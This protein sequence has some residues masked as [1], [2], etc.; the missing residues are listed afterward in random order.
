MG[1][2]L[3]LVDHDALFDYSRHTAIVVNEY[4]LDLQADLEQLNNLIYTTYDANVLQL[5]PQC[6]CQYLKGGQNVGLTCPKCHTQCLTVTEKPLESVLWIAAPSEVGVLI[7]PQAWIIL[8]KA[9]TVSGF[10]LLEWLT[11]PYMSESPA[12]VQGILDR[13]HAAGFERGLKAFHAQFDALMQ[14]LIVERVIK[15]HNQTQRDEIMQFIHENRSVLFSRH[16]PIPS[17]LALITEKNARGT[18]V[19]RVMVP[20]VEA[21]RTIC[22][23]ENSVIPLSYKRKESKTVKAIMYLVKYY[24][25]FFQESLPKKT[26]LFRKHIY[27]GRIH[28]SFR[29]VISSL[30]EP[31]VYDELHLPWSMSVMLLKFHLLSKLMNRPDLHY[32]PGEAI[33]FLNEY[34]QQ[35]HPLIDSLFKQLID[36]SPVKGIVVGLQRNPSLTRGSFQMLRVTKIK[37]DPTVNTISLSLLVL[38]AYNADKTFHVMYA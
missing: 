32:P 31:H 38:G 18:T 36:E 30:S 16:L 33:R 10:N 7:N 13:L 37:T 22:G 11:N 21:V 23:I 1:V 15:K 26:G 28:F 20:A 2:Y 17:K 6:D 4:N 19:D 8:S 12:K 9:L 27:G 14:F 24:Q 5:L 34:T 35:Y 25:L 29:A 3:E